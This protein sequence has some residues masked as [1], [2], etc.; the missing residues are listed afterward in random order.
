M[1]SR[2]SHDSGMPLIELQRY[3][4][5]AIV[6]MD[7]AAAL[8]ARRRVG[9]APSTTSVDLNPEATSRARLSRLNES[10]MVKVRRDGRNRGR[11]RTGI[12]SSRRAEGSPFIEG[13]PPIVLEQ[14]E[15]FIEPKQRSQ[16]RQDAPV[17]VDRPDHAVVATGDRHERVADVR[18]NANPPA[19]SERAN[20]EPRAFKSSGEK[21]AFAK[22]VSLPPY[23]PDLAA[24]QID[25]AN[26]PY[27][28]LTASLE[29]GGT[30]ELSLPTWTAGANAWSSIPWNRKRGSAS[31]CA[32]GLPLPTPR[33]ARPRDGGHQRRAPSYRQSGH[34]A[35][36][37]QARRRGAH[38]RVRAHRRR[39]SALIL[40]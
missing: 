31:R 33:S 10:T 39:A 32:N 8:R 18:S 6:T 25:E 11:G 15:L 24:Y 29:A 12:R 16:H 17:D 2:A 26:N 19:A 5:R 9:Q 30:I 22:A 37:S 14:L 23:E 7:C 1:K 27:R 34:R 20:G 36:G 40:Y 4:F 35:Q 3:K 13:I 28:L 38:A 21:Q